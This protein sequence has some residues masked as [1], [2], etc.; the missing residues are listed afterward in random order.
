MI[1]NIA[2]KE[3][4]ALLPHHFQR[5]DEA[6]DARIH[7]HGG[8]PASRGYGFSELSFDERLLQE[9]GQLALRTC[10]GAFSSGIP[11]DLAWLAGALAREVPGGVGSQFDALPVYLA[12][13]MPTDGAPALGAS[14]GVPYLE[15]YRT[16]PEL[17]TGGD[18]KELCLRVPNLSLRFGNESNDGFLLLPLARLVRAANG[19]LALDRE[20]VPT[21]LDI[22][23]STA[24]T[25][26]LAELIDSMNLRLAAFDRQ[27][28]AIDSAGMR[29]W[30]EMVHLRTSVARL[31]HLRACQE[32]HPE[33]LY[34]EL[35]ALAGGLAMTRACAPFQPGYRHWELATSFASLLE[36]LRRAFSTVTRS[37]N[38][39]K[40]MK[41]DGQVLFGVSLE[42]AALA[43]S[44]RCFL[45]VKSDLPV[46][47]FV[48]MFAQQAKIAPRSKLQT[49]ILSAL[50]GIDA[51]MCAMPAFYLASGHVC[52]ELVPGGALWSALLEEGELGVYVPQV[53]EVSEI[54]FLAEGE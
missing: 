10:R 1:P 31:E 6:V 5:S 15:S 50:R 38:L 24:L 29:S 51:Q 11:F 37:R 13:P 43:A 28:P 32:I 12:M 20:F 2:W 23:A 4:L 45:A 33:R 16:F 9:S 49:I 54:E 47:R 17:C 27:N 53:L 40:M 7:A 34:T 26:I 18:R 3:G 41:R 30:L 21:V 35:V 19:A 48:G 14:A 22:H 42:T 25:T 39:V 46:D 52:L 36:W 8:E 44:R